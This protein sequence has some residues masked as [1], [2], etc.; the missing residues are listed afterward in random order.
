[1]QAIKKESSTSTVS[2]PTEA[3]KALYVARASRL[4][5]FADNLGQDIRLAKLLGFSPARLHRLI[6][7]RDVPFTEKIARVIEEKLNKAPGWLDSQ[8]DSGLPQKNDI[9]VYLLEDV[10]QMTEAQPSGFFRYIT[11]L[12]QSFFIQ[13]LTSSYEPLIP[14][15]AKVLIDKTEDT[16]KIGSTYLIAYSINNTWTKPIFRKYV[17]QGFLNITTNEVESISDFKIYG[18]CEAIINTNI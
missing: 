6:R 3:L 4:A 14:A 7:K 18:R 10:T 8:Q 16:P 2:Q 15:G 5:S 1:M 9:P 13:I 12:S 11:H 17:N